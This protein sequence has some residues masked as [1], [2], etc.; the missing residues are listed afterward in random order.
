[1]T[2][3][4]HIGGVVECLFGLLCGSR[5][6]APAN[7]WYVSFCGIDIGYMI[8]IQ[9]RVDTDECIKWQVKYGY[10]NS[11]RPIYILNFLKQQTET[12][13][14]LSLFLDQMN[15]FIII[16][17]ISKSHTYKSI[18]GNTQIKNQTM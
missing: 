18:F 6:S 2:G 11:R 17:H 13:L 12:T 16:S 3:S 7:S 15:I 1:M 14:S 9:I 8:Q 4:H 5:N 10:H